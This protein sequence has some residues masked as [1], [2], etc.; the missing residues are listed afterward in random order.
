MPESVAAFWTDLLSHSKGGRSPS[1]AAH[2]QACGEPLP[3][4]AFVSPGMEAG[5][6]GLSTWLPERKLRVTPKIGCLQCITNL[7]CRLSHFLCLTMQFS[8]V[9]GVFETSHDLHGLCPHDLTLE[10]LESL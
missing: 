5:A 7:S 6:G 2:P 10:P 4:S 3:V 1:R 8:G 9:S